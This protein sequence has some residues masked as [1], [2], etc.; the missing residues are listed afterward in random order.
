LLADDHPAVGKSVVSLLEL[1]FDVVGMV[2]NG[3]DMLSEAT[4]LPPDVVILDISMPMLD[5]FEA[6]AKLSEIGSRAKV[7]L[8]TVHD[9]AEF[10]Q[11]G[12][13]A[14]ALG[15]VLK[16]RLT[17]DLSTAVREILAGHRFMSPGLHGF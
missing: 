2:A 11:A 6:A 3:K 10:V 12:L 16:S 1:E 14:G 7:I 15:Y 13:A 8:L 17:T 4:R 5:G 9:D